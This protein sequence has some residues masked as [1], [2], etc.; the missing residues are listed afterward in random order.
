LPPERE[1][2]EQ[3]GVSRS[4]L[5]QALKVLLIMGVLT[6]RVRKGTF[7]A[8][9]ASTI[10]AEPLHFLILFDTI[11]HSELFEARMIVEPELAARAAERA[12]ID[13]LQAL[14]LSIRAMEKAGAD[15]DHD[16]VVEADL[17][18]HGAIFRAA[19]NKICYSMFSAVNAALATSIGRIAKLT[20]VAHT[21][22]LHRAIYSAIYQRKPQEARR[23]MIEHLVDARNLMIESASAAKVTDIRAHVSKSL[24][25]LSSD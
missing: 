7:L 18:F 13:D 22:G 17:A 15:R 19:G 1:L 12:T 11:S 2:A 9:S 14:R 4:S 6:Q 16:R 5:R 23:R 10:L 21:L 24:A 3:F 20:E 8:D 25:S